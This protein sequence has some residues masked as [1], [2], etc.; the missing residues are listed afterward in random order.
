M[1]GPD[2]ADLIRVALWAC[3]VRSPHAAVL[4]GFT[5]PEQVAMNLTCLGERPDDVQIRAARTVMAE[6][7]ARLDAAGEVFLDEL[8][9]A[10]GGPQ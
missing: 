10:A 3:L 1:I 5:S 7:Q 2:P 9:S 8:T 6:V 4:T